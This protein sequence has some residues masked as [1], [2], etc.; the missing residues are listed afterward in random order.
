MSPAYYLAKYQG[1]VTRAV[2]GNKFL[3]NVTA[4]N[5]F[6][7]QTIFY[8][9]ASQAEVQE[10]TFRAQWSRLREFLFFLP[11]TLI[12]AFMLQAILGNKCQASGLNFDPQ[13][14]G[15]GYWFLA[16]NSRRFQQLNL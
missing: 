10:D 14:I 2:L 13:G 15:V 16:R 6:I 11:A 8:N 5:I 4:F 3:Y 9:D 7:N 1:K 12:L